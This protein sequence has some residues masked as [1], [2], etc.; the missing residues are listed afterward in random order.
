MD[1][2]FYPKILDSIFKILLS[3]TKLI[4]H[5]NINPIDHERLPFPVKSLFQ[6]LL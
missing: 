4:T 6:N 5:T 3:T 2:K 1:S